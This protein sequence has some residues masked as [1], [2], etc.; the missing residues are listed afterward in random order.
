MTNSAFE[1]APTLST[2]RQL[3]TATFSGVSRVVSLRGF[4]E[5][6]S[7]EIGSIA[8]RTKRIHR[9]TL[10]NGGQH[11]FSHEAYDLLTQ[12]I[13]STGICRNST[14]SSSF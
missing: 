10:F 14:H 8:C 9:L 12:F 5:A 11:L 7:C 2:K 4:A 13:H 6:L 1:D 3:P